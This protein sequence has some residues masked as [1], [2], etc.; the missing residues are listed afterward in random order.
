VDRT[1]SIRSGSACTSKIETLVACAI[2]GI[3][4]YESRSACEWRQGQYVQ[5]DAMR[6][7]LLVAAAV[8]VSV[9]T[10]VCV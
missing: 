8:S 3:S 10:S 5:H 9:Q 6:Q 1:S 4:G 2:D 7:G